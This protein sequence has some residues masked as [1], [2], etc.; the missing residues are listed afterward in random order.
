MPI[1]HTHYIANENWKGIIQ[2][3]KNYEN[4]IKGKKYPPVFA[5]YLGVGIYWFGLKA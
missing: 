2:G 1:F 4:I 3:W 5:L